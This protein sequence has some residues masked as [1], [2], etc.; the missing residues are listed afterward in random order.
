M[1]LQLK[2]RQWG[3]SLGIVIPRETIER[4]HISP[5]EEIVVEIRKKENVLKDLWGAFKFKKPTHELLKEVRR[6]L[7]SKWSR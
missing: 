7:E 2:T 4:L 1:E 6:E 3:H 5:D